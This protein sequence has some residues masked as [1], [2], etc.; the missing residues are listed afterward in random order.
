MI[1]SSFPR[2]ERQAA[3]YKSALDEAR[4]KPVVFR[5]LDIGGDKVLPYLR[6]TQEENP[7]L[8][9]RGIR[10]ALDRPALLRTQVRALIRAAGARPLHLMIPMISEATEIAIVRQLVDR[11][12]ELARQRGLPVP[13]KLNFGIMIEVPS[14]LFQLEQVLP[15]VDFV[16]IGSND[17]MQYLYAADRGNDRVSNR[18]DPMS[19]PF[20]RAMRSIIQAAARHKTE[21]TL[22]GEI[23]GRALEVIALIAIGFRSLSMAPA[24][25]GPVKAMILSLDAG[26][27]AAHFSPMI[28]RDTGSLREELRRFAENE[29]LEL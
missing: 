24:S 14:L 27:A 1:A 15:M 20:L 5:S 9:W 21:V 26:R 2:L 28:D 16:S 29:G 13:E 17:L 6:T 7:A 25:I 11:E 10:L 12:F 23:G 19:P 8:G 18:F 22:C 4:G 3:A